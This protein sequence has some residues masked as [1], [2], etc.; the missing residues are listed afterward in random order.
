MILYFNSV[1]GNA[2]I[3]IESLDTVDNFF[4]I[5]HNRKF[6]DNMNAA[7]ESLFLSLSVADIETEMEQHV[8]NIKEAVSV[9]ISRFMNISTS[10]TF[11]RCFG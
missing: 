10:K 2:Q 7:Q 6:R 1:V 5:S 11:P 8:A 3:Q 4:F 9:S